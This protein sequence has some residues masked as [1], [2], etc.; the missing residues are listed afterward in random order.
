[1]RAIV[2]SRHGGPD[3][4]ELAEREDPRP[5]EGQI[6]VEVAVA[7]VNFLDIN[8]REGRGPSTGS[9][10]YVPGVEGAGTVVAI[11]E[12]VTGFSI[13]EQVAWVDAPGS[14]AERL[15]LRAERAVPVPEGVALDV[16]G[17]TLL[18]GLTAH[19][20]CMSTYPVQTGDVAVVHAAAGGVGLLLTQ[21]INN[22]GATVVATTSTPEK[23]ELAR[24]AGA[25][26][27]VDYDDFPKV[28]RDVTGGAG[29]AV[30]Y[31]GVGKDTFDNSLAALRQRGSMVLYG[32]SSGAVQP[33]ELTRLGASGSLY[34]TR[35]LLR[36]YTSSRGELVR[37][38]TDVFQMIQRGELEVHSGGRYTLADA[39]T[40]HDALASRRTTGKLT[41]LPE[42]SIA[43]SGR[44]LVVPQRWLV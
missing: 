10:P 8:R 43:E 9:L 22:R 20:L 27:V 35:P 12:G 39:A 1:M 17:A 5:S 18:Q 11:G 36:H 13:G 32:A 33:F 41:L 2:V 14:Y 23:A 37:R 4:L 21:M 31:D 6:V 30:V 44:W 16:A 42:R 3:V 26:H 25:A 15:A 38:A 24:K 7:G 29:A 28:V 40:A 34:I 19:Y